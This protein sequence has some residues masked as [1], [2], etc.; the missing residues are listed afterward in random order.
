MQAHCR[1]GIAS[2]PGH[3]TPKSMPPIKVKYKVDGR[4]ITAS[5]NV[6]KIT[7]PEYLVRAALEKKHK[8]AKTIEILEIG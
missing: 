3:L 5:V 7:A 6:K 4:R 8:R 1:A 2:I